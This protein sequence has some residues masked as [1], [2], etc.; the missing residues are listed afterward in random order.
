MCTYNIPYVSV[1]TIGE[2]W[3][4]LNFIM[5]ETFHDVQQFTDWFNRPFEVEDDI[6]TPQ[7]VSGKRKRKSISSTSTTILFDDERRLIISSLHRVLRPFLLRRVKADVAIDIPPKVERLVLCP[8]SEL[9]KRMYFDIKNKVNR[10]YT[11]TELTSV[12]SRFA[13]FVSI[14]NPMMQ[15]RLYYTATLLV[16][17]MH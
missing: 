8:C 17:S 4:L 1:N 14:S 3:S 13:A 5:P 15:Y 10:A 12:N 9:Q 16:N 2:L 7:V 11:T 6:N